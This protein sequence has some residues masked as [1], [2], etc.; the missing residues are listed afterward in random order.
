[1][2]GG[3]DRLCTGATHPIHGHRGD[4]NGKAGVNSRL[5]R[6]I[7]LVA[8]LHGI[9]HHHRAD[10]LRPQARPLKGAADGR[11]SKLDGRNVLQRAAECSDSGTDRFSDHDRVQ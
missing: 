3:D 6:R 5:P 8:G 11:R 7:H 2:S 1:M 9:S 10:L 4:L